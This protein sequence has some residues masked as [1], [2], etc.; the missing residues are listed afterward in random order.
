MAHYPGSSPHAHTRMAED[1]CSAFM[2]PSLTHSHVW[3]RSHSDTRTQPS[4]AATNPPSKL[5]PE[6][7]DSLEAEISSRCALWRVSHVERGNKTPS[8]CKPH[9][10]FGLYATVSGRHRGRAEGFGGRAIEDINRRQA[11]PAWTC[12]EKVTCDL[13]RL[14]HRNVSL[15]DVKGKKERLLFRKSVNE[16]KMWLDDEYKSRSN[17]RVRA[18][19]AVLDNSNIFDYFLLF[20]E[21]RF[22][23]HRVYNRTQHVAGTKKQF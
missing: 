14:E 22:H 4:Q 6:C 10:Y 1:H 23:F 8:H 17:Q 19:T 16:K 3:Q 21:N 11:D 13:I 2:T 9:K 12:F 5:Q 7:G 20:L 18:F 15:T